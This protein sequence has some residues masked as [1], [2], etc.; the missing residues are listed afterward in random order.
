MFKKRS[1]IIFDGVCN[2]CNGGVNFIISRDPKNVFNFTP[3]QSATAQKLIEKYYGPEFKSD[4]FLLIKNEICFERSDGVLEIVKELSSFWFLLRI[5]KFIP[6]SGRDYFYNIIAKHRYQ[7]FGKRD[8]CM[9]P[10]KDIQSRF[11]DI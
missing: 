8:H 2:L 7:I 9:V 1:I 10:N 4:T 6:K 11:I 3:I 5:F